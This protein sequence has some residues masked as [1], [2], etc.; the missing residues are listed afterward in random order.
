LERY[1]VEPDEDDENKDEP[2]AGHYEE[3]S[4]FSTPRKGLLTG[5]VDFFVV[6]DVHGQFGQVF[7][8][9]MFDFISL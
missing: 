7:C 2:G 9:T 5:L 8:S 3:D 6:P 4:L 1:F